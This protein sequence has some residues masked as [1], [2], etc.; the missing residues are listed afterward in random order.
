MAKTKELALLASALLI[1]GC[2]IPGGAAEPFDLVPASAASVAVLSPSAIL[3][4]PDFAYFYSRAN[5]NMSI[6][7]EFAKAEE[8]TGIQMRTVTREVMFSIGTGAGRRSAAFLK[9]GFDASAAEQRIR[10]DPSWSASDYQGYSVFRKPGEENAIAFI[11]G[12]LLVGSP[13]AVQ[14]AIDVKKGAPSIRSNE[15]LMGIFSRLNETAELV[16]VS[17]PGF[18]PPQLSQPPLNASFAGLVRASGISISKRL[19]AVGVKAVL[20]AD[21]PS[22]AGAIRGSLSTLFSFASVT[23]ASPGS[24]LGAL[25]SGISVSSDGNYVAVS[26]SATVDDL[27]AAE[28]EL[29]RH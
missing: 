10:S 27:K 29:G 17:E 11:D 2:C 7:S 13:S 12:S 19:Q 9:G 25:I 26:L 3:S 28:S 16:Y 20:A 15:R 18:L 1:F 5:Q 23:F 8:L 21:S 6:S 22:D 24:R 14:A 4:D